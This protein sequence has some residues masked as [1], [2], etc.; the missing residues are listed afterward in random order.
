MH[1]HWLTCAL[2]VGANAS[3][4]ASW[5]AKDGAAAWMHGYWMFDWADSC[6]P[7]TLFFLCLFVCLMW[8]VLVGESRNAH[9]LV[10]LCVKT[11]WWCVDHAFR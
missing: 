5:A 3:R 11:N 7:H 10:A 6:V 1:V 4:V 2:K 8:L 9:V